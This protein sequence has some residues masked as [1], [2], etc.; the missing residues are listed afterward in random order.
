MIPPQLLAAGGALALLGGL[1]AGWTLRDWKADADQLAALEKAQ[2]REDSLRA[3]AEA[4]A[5]EYEESRNAEQAQ[6]VVR[7]GELRTIYRDV[8][9]RADCGAP[10]AARGVLDS[11]VAAANARAAGEP[12]GALPAAERAAAGAGRP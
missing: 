4:R 8:P 6:S 9:V 1:L 2:K 5:A 3:R 12:G 7:Q 11:A 10:A